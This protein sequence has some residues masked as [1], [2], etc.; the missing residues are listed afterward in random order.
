MLAMCDVILEAE[1]ISNRACLMYYAR[2]GTARTSVWQT[3]WEASDMAEADWDL[4]VEDAVLQWVAGV[5][6]L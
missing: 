4:L 1:Q 5:Q 2:I 6:Y 3:S